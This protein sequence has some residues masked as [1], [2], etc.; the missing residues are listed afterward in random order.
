MPTEGENPY[1]ASLVLVR[2][3]IADGMFRRAHAD[4]RG[5]LANGQPPPTIHEIAE[6]VVNALHDRRPEPV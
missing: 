6:S 3:I 5:L 2:T 4:D 1:D